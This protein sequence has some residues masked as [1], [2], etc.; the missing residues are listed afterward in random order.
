MPLLPNIQYLSNKII[1]D[2][3]ESQVLRKVI[4]KFIQYK[5]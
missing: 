1:Q 3:P 4:N 5:L 2:N